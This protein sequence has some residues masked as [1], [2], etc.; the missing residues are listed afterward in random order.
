M[1]SGGILHSRQCKYLCA[2]SVNPND[3]I[4]I[5]QLPISNVIDYISINS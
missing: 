2:S 4:G 1:D 3:F 5:F